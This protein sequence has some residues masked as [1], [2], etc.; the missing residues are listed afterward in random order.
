[1]LA[2]KPPLFLHPPRQPIKRLQ[3]K[4]R[5]TIAVG[6]ACK[7]GIVLAADTK[8][9][10]GEEHTYVEKISVRDI[11]E[12]QFGIAGS[13]YDYILDYITPRIMEAII[14]GNPWPS[15]NDCFLELEKLMGQLYSGK[16]LKAYPRDSAA[17]I[18]TSSLLAIRL[19]SSAQPVLFSI[20]SSLVTSVPE[21]AVIGYG[22]MK[23]MAREMWSLDLTVEQAS[24]AALYLIYDTKRR[25]GAVGGVTNILKLFNDGRADWERTWDQPARESLLNDLR[26]LHHRM[27]VTVTTPGIPDAE[28]GRVSTALSRRAVD[29]REAF[30]KI[31]QEYKAWLIQAMGGSIVKLEDLPQFVQDA[32]KQFPQKSRPS[33]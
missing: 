2:C 3:K 30:Q 29:I 23:E 11:G 20:N 17:D 19:K 31:E 28:Y 21:F 6:F 24:K 16:P 33:S 26:L 25:S 5:M 14:K 1:M 9:S 18:Y 27:V 4:K 12:C 15:M 10:Y 32:M 8:E 7:D 13:G 22:P